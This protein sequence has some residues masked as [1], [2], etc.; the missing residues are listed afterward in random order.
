MQPDGNSF[1]G[2]VVLGSVNL[3]SGGED[4]ILDQILVKHISFKV[5]KK[6]ADLKNTALYNKELLKIGL[7]VVL[8]PRYHVNA[9]QCDISAKTVPIWLHHTVW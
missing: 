9:F 4:S 5:I 2:D 1:W 3:A 7:N 6:I 8:I